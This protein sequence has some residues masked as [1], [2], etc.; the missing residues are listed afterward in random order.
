MK[1]NDT[2]TISSCRLIGLIGLL[3][4][5]TGCTKGYQRQYRDTSV[6][7]KPP[8]IEVISPVKVPLTKQPK[9][10]GKQVKLIGSDQSSL[11]EVNND[12]NHTW[13][14]LAQALSLNEIKVIDT[15]RQEGMLY[16]DF[17]AGERASKDHNWLETINWFLFSDD[18]ISRYQLTVQPK[19]K[20]TQIRAKM[21][22]IEY[23]DFIDDHRD[24]FDT[25]IDHSDQLIKILYQTLKD[26]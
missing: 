7:E 17:M 24:E 23:D 18:Q 5:T 8:Q 15:N 6:L 26:E 14:F 1:N 9:G 25:P 16:V 2:Q 11:I 22:E 10:L 4:L 21:I 19:Q 13:T 3:L 12:F 20:V